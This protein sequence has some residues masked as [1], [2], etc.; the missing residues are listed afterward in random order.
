MNNVVMAPGFAVLLSIVLTCFGIYGMFLAVQTQNQPQEPAP[1]AVSVASPTPKPIASAQPTAT[2]SAV[3]TSNLKTIKGMNC[4]KPNNQ[5][6]TNCQEY[7]YTYDP[8]VPVADFSS[9]VGG[10]PPPII[11]PTAQY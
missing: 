6:A 9:I 11:T 1:C 7:T 8:N 2:P 3:P 5:G 10:T 4:S